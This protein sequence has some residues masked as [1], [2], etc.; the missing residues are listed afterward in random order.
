MDDDL[1]TWRKLRDLDARL[2]GPADADLFAEARRLAEALGDEAQRDLYDFRLGVALLRS[3]R[4]EEAARWLESAPEAMRRLGVPPADAL[5]WRARSRSPMRRDEEAGADYDAAISA[6]VE[7]LNCRAV[8]DARR[9]GAVLLLRS[10]SAGDQARARDLLTAAAAQLEL[11][12]DRY[13]WRE[14]T[15]LL[16]LGR[17]RR[18][19]RST[20][21][22]DHARRLRTATEEVVAA[23][24]AGDLDEARWLLTTMLAGLDDLRAD[25]TSRMRLVLGIADLSAEVAWRRGDF[26]QAMDVV[27]RAV[28][29]WEPAHVRLGLAADA[30]KLFARYASVSY[31]LDDDEADAAA[32]TRAEELA[33]ATNDPQVSLLTRIQIA[34]S[35]SGPEAVR[36]L[37]ELERISADRGLVRVQVEALQGLAIEPEDP[38]ERLAAVD[39]AEALVPALRGFYPEAALAQLREFLVT[40]RAT[41]PAETDPSG[42]G[43]PA[44]GNKATLGHTAAALRFT[45][46]DRDAALATAVAVIAQI[47]AAALERR[48]EEAFRRL[49][50]DWVATLEAL[51]DLGTGEA[52]APGDPLLA[53]I[54]WSA[55]VTG[56]DEMLIHRYAVQ[57]VPA[58]SLL[59][60]PRTLAGAPGQALVYTVERTEGESTLD[61]SAERAAWAAQPRWATFP[62]DL[63]QRLTADEFTGALSRRGR[64]AVAYI[65]SH[66]KGNG[67]DHSLLHA[68]G[69]VL[70]VR[71][72]LRLWWPEPV[73]LSSCHVGGMAP[74]PGAD[75]L[76]LPLVCLLRGASFVIG[77]NEEIGYKGASSIGAALAERLATS[78]ETPAEVLRSAQLRWLARRPDGPFRS[79]APYQVVS[80]C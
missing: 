52:I 67:L 40:L 39:R 68:D 51:A 21:G 49:R 34:R 78:D 14:T 62:R 74:A 38:A 72:A 50:G 31:L 43:A 61:T 55:G 16:G 6:G 63:T 25:E 53:G 65:A 44:A 19:L 66:G 77:C 27:R 69:S 10:G 79:W 26:A 64:W 76:G 80:L 2:G 41:A 59:T 18:L 75:P 30:A 48:R 46:G 20:I 13:A 42:A 24:L 22:W 12:G 5:L 70:S 37:V 73:V 60:G 28:A 3:G 33:D 56:P 1:T 35:R 29:Q 45:I 4:I 57:I 11:L 47:E 17:T 7:E 23:V 8:V 58:L 15:A 71:E 54:P 36:Q 32:A 9:E